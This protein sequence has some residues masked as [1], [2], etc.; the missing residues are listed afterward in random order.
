VK[1]KDQLMIGE[2]IQFRN[3]HCGLVTALRPAFAKVM[4]TH[5]LTGKL[6]QT[7]VLYNE[8]SHDGTTWYTN[9]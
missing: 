5:P 7:H 4:L 8:L 6:K 3:G 1:A 2:S 9:C